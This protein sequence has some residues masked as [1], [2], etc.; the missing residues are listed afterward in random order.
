MCIFWIGYGEAES[1]RILLNGKPVLAST[2]PGMSWELHLLHFVATSD[3][4]QLRFENNSPKGDS[5]V[6]IDSVE[7]IGE[8]GFGCAV[9]DVCTHNGRTKHK[10]RE[11]AMNDSYTDL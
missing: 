11:G 10:D 7:G 9:V 1:F 2:H 3:K 4:M 5:T 8:L 6:F